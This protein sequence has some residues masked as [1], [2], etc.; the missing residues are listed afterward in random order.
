MELS[1]PLN[2]PRFAGGRFS[3]KVSDVDLIK[4]VNCGPASRGGDFLS[5]R[6]FSLKQGTPNINQVFTADRK[7]L[8]APCPGF[9]S[10]S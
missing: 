10:D 8:K 6:G 3:F 7:S 1:P 2:P 9:H 4:C 5:S